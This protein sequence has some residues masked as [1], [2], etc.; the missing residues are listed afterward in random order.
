[1][2]TFYCVSSAFYD[3]GKCIAEIVCSVKA[4][5][6]PENTFKH[7]TRA[8]YYCDW[9][10]DKKEATKFMAETLKA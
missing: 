8:D 10:H 3:D 6:K 7:G 9:F 1:M 2:K 5:K 4:E